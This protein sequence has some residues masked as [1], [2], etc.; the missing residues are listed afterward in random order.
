[1]EETSIQISKAAAMNVAIQHL[2][3]TLDPSA[4]EWHED[5]YYGE[6]DVMGVTLKVERVDVF[7][8]EIANDSIRA[9]FDVHV[10]MTQFH[11]SACSELRATMTMEELRPGDGSGN[12]SVIDVFVLNARKL[13]F[14]LT[15]PQLAWLVMDAATDNL[16]TATGEATFE[17]PLMHAI[18]QMVRLANQ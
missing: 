1:M 18:Q 3:K 5:V 17:W 6:D 14:F 4:F 13:N 11:D 9:T 8:C 12:K 7:P 15:Q 2:I 16:N 10:K